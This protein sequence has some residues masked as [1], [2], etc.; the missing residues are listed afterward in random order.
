[1][2]SRIERDMTEQELRNIIRN[3][4]KSKLFEQEIEI[5]PFSEAEEQ[6]LGKFAELKTN[7]I[8]ILYTNPFGGAIRHF[9]SLVNCNR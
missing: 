2:L 3:Q 7:N 8:G 1:M 6:F 9:I 4:L 5:S